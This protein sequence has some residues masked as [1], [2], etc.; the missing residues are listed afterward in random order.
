MKCENCGS[1]DL[2]WDRKNGNIV[3][4]N[5]GLVI[6]TI[7]D[8]TLINTEDE[9]IIISPNLFNNI[10]KETKDFIFNKFR[11]NIIYINGIKHIIHEDSL[12]ALD[13]VSR[14]LKVK[15]IYENINKLG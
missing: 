13:L 3:C 5:C 14:N 15:K 4:S 6:E 12:I 2:V 1:S 7:Y 11:K 10:R 8:N 9:Y